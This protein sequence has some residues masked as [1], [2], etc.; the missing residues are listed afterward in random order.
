MNTMSQYVI[1]SNAKDL[2]PKLK[3]IDSSAIDRMTGNK[4][5]GMTSNEKSLRYNQGQCF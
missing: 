2:A 4:E 1:L 5:Q 3:A